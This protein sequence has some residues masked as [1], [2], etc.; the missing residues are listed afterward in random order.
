MS[1]DTYIKLNSELNFYGEDGKI[2]FDKD[3]QAARA[4]FLEHVNPNT[5]FF[6]NLDERLEYLV[7]EGYYDED[8]L[9]QY[10]L[11]ELHALWDFAHSL[12]HRFRTF[13]G[14]TKFYRQYALKNWAGDRYLERYE[15]RVVMTSLYLAQGDAEFAERLID[16]IISGRFQPATPTFLNAGKRQRGA[17]VSCFLLEVDDSMNGIARAVNAALQLSK[18]G[19]GVSF[20][21]NNLRAAG[22]PIKG[23]E[24]QASGVVPVMKILEDSIKYSNQLGQR[25]GSAAAYLN[26]FHL[27]IETFLDSRRE[28]ADDAIR[29]NKLS[30]GIVIPDVFFTLAKE[31]SPMYLFSPYD[32]SKKYGKPFSDIN[33]TEVY[34]EL[35]DDENIRK[36][37]VSAREMLSRLAETQMESG[38]P[39]IMFEDTVNE[40]NPVPGKVKFSNLCSEILQTSTSSDIADD[41]TY[42]VLG[43]DISCNLA[44]L[45]LARLMENDGELLEDTVKDAV[46]ALSAVSEMSTEDLECAPT[47]SYGNDMTHAIGLGVMNLHGYLA[48]EGIEYGSD[49]ALELVDKIFE[50][51]NFHSLWASSDLARDY[52]S[53]VGFDQ[54]SYITGEYFHQYFNSSADRVDNNWQPT[55]DDWKFLSDKVV[56]HG[57]YNAY[58]MAVAPTGSIS[59]INDATPSI[60]PVTDKVEARKE[61]TVGQVYYPAPEMTNDNAHLYRDMYDLGWKAIIDTYAAAQRHVDQGMSLTLGFSQNATTR[62]INKAQMYAWRQ[63]IKTLYYIRVK[64]NIIDGLEDTTCV[65]CS[66]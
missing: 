65:S 14:A 22:D 24:G 46:R 45:N 61:G 38:Y 3:R 64:M 12:R 21:L 32:V 36:K 44:S 49:E 42:N 29:I 60:L 50:A 27:D 53:F 30:L 25:A 58:R 43:K 13:M 8:I 1:E 28:N 10:T 47:I 33:L 23:M 15:D 48:S 20:N 4:Y 19:G 66:V 34:S 40:A 5:V 11:D 55:K 6:Y 39:Y 52:G 9:N 62:E 2:Q 63:G 7:E 54:S 17:M 51:I 37:K 31:N 18:R 26:I 35:V 57:V 16:H 59:Y 41:L 56:N